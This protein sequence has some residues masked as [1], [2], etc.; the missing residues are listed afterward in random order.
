M[1]TCKEARRYSFIRRLGE[2]RIIFV[3]RVSV[4]F[5]LWIVLSAIISLLLVL[6]EYSIS[7]LSR[8]FGSQKKDSNEL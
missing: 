2:N 3:T 1:K 7:R 6:W 5:A 4:L 8:L